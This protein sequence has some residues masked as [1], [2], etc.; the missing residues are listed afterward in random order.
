MG[1]SGCPHSK[2][3]R[4]ASEPG[5]GLVATVTFT[6][7]GGG[8]LGGSEAKKICVPQIDLQ[9]WA[10]LISFI[11]FLRKRFLMWVGGWMGQAEE[12]RLPSPPP[13][14][15]NGKPWPRRS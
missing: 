9:F 7:G 1:A 12:P 14:P 8:W 4:G 11:F 15:G 13:P 5:H 2:C 3:A 6:W 10:P